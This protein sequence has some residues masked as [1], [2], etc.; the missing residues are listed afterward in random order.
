M[1][2]MVTTRYISAEDWPEVS[3]QFRDLSFEQ[4]LTYGTAAAKR[5]GG[6]LKFLVVEADGRMIAA[7]SIRLKTIPGLG[8]GIAWVPSG[9]L[10]LP[11]DGNDPDHNRLQDILTA[12][13]DQLCGREGHVLRLR[14]PG[15]ALH[16]KPQTDRS[17][18]VCDFMPT[19]K[20]PT[21]LSFAMDLRK[22]H[23]T[24]LKELMGKWRTDLRYAWK[25]GLSLDTGYS[26]ELQQRFL[27]LFD[28]IQKEK[29]FQPDISPEFHFDL[30]G[31]D[32]RYDILIATKDGQDLAGIVIGTSGKVTTYL[33]GATADAG[34]RL[35]A[36]FFLTWE[37]I[38][39]S[40]DRG[41]DWYD[42]GGVDFEENPAVARFKD[43]MNGVAIDAP[44]PYE[45]RPSWPWS[46]LVL[47]LEAAYG[48]LK[49][50]R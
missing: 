48:R 21:Y 15:I 50:R 16:D 28:D 29:G 20:V 10:V 7:T 14:F 24:M 37:G 49:G 47:G 45:A 31:E 4:S 33:F 42:L 41:L 12:L 17:A 44:G 2:S 13:R 39:L 26:P 9:P 5:I 23:D 19:D 8:R 40:R 46:T 27:S 6:V 30:E 11:V 35:R 34:R 38:N 3:Q 1:S 22:D 32:L 43:R 25:S 18:A 36:G